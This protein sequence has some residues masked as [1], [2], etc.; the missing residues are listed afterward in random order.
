MAQKQIDLELHT[1]GVEHGYTIC[2]NRQGD[3][4]KGRETVGTHNKVDIDVSC[5]SGFYPDALWHQHPDG[6]V[7]P[8]P[9]DCRAAKRHKINHLCIS[10][11]ETGETVCHPVC[12]KCQGY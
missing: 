9:A 3:F 11:P 1:D 7:E 10:V 6:T 4:I 8:S 2:R 5:P 12:Q